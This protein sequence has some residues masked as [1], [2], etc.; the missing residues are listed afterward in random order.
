MLRQPAGRHLYA[1][2]LA[3]ETEAKVSK[4]AFDKL[5]AAGEGT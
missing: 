1:A 5:V 2:N 3:G 4:E